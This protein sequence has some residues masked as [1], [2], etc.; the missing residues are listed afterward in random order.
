MSLPRD[1]LGYLEIALKHRATAPKQRLKGA[2]RAIR[3]KVVIRKRFDADLHL[4]EILYDL[5]YGANR[6]HYTRLLEVNAYEARECNSLRE[7][8]SRIL[9]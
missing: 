3:Y 4:V 7:H 9:D 5:Q 2:L 1:R 6:L 8:I